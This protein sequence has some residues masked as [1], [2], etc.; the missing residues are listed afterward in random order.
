MLSY[1]D[2]PGEQPSVGLDD[3]I[4]CSWFNSLGLDQVSKC[5]QAGFLQ[6]SKYVDFT[7]L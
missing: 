6:W 5:L 1:D 4:C 7:C 3:N 2:N